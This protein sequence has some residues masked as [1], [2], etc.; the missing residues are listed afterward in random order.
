LISKVTKLFN[1]LG[2]EHTFLSFSFIIEKL[3]KLF[4]D[5]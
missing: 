3:G 4:L 1:Y 2:D 5:M